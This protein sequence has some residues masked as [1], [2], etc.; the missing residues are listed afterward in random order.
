MAS[1]ALMYVNVAAPGG[2][3]LP[4]ATGWK[5][6]VNIAY[7]DSTTN[8]RQVDDAVIQLTDAQITTVALLKQNLANAVKQWLIDNKGITVANVV[9]EEWAVIAV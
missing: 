2:A 5:F 3:V 4:T 7:K 8:Q 1:A 6:N 9:V